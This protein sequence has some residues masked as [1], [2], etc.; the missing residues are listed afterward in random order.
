MP[1]WLLRRTV[2]MHIPLSFAFAMVR[3][4]ASGPTSGPSPR[5]A[6]SASDTGDSRIVSSG[7]L[8]LSKP[9]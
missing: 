6:S 7:A 5:L 4:I 2:V 8:G 9:H 1:K 3:R